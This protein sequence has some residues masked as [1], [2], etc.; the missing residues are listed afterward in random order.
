MGFIK[1]NIENLQ[2]MIQKKQEN[3]GYLVNVM[4]MKL[5]EQASANSKPAK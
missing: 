1:S 5:Q 2:E 4:Q 3:M